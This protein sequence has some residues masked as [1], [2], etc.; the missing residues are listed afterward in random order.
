MATTAFGIGVLVL[1]VLSV[2]GQFGVLTAISIVYSFLASLLVLPSALVVWDRFVN[3][4]PEE[5]MG[6]K[7]GAEHGT[8]ADLTPGADPATEGETL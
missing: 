6:P 8:K 5:P 1:A 3:G 4:D 2:L 7:A